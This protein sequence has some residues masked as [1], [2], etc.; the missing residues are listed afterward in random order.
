MSSA[1]QLGL[2]RQETWG[3]LGGRGKEPFVESRV[4]G[5][6]SSRK[7][8]VR[9]Q[10]DEGALQPAERVGNGGLITLSVF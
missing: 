1:I 4:P 6:F 8:S 9:S 2:A 3:K 5:F 10:N 7:M